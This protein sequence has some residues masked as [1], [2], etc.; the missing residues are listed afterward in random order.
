MKNRRRLTY[1]NPR[2]QA[3]R[4][5]AL[6][7]FASGLWLLAGCGGLTEAGLAERGPEGAGEHSDVAL[8]APGTSGLPII[9]G[10][11]AEASQI[12]GTVYLQVGSGNCTG[13]LIAPSVVVTA[14]HCVA[15]QPGTFIPANQILVAAGVLDVGYATND[16]VYAVAGVA[17]HPQFT[18]LQSGYTNDPTGLGNMY[19]LAV[20]VLARP[21]QT[22]SPVP[23]FP[24][25]SFDPQVPSGATV[26]ISGYGMTQ[27]NGY[28]SSGRLYLANTPYQRR[29]DTELLLGGTGVPDTCSGDSG[30]PT[31]AIVGGQP[32]LIGATSRGIAGTT[33]ECGAGGI[34]TFVPAFESWITEITG[35]AYT[36]GASPPGGGGSGPCQGECGLGQYTACTCAAND[37]CRWGNDGTCDSECADVV[38]QPFA[39]S[40][41]CAA[42]PPSDPCDGT[43]TSPA[44]NACTCGSGDP[45]GWRQDGV[46]DAACAQV[47][48]APFDDSVDCAEAPGDDAGPT[49]PTPTGPPAEGGT[50]P[51]GSDG[52]NG[53]TSPAPAPAQPGNATGSANHGSGEAGARQVAASGFT[54][55]C[56]SAGAGAA[57]WLAPW[58]ALAI[59]GGLCHRPRGRACRPT[60][61]AEG[62]RRQIA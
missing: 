2:M 21:V 51:D 3:I 37:P 58:A 43:C 16:Q 1:D 32:Y 7:A 28:G 59:L 17:A 15:P 19:D 41:D 56:A 62:T 20:L 11:P 18:Y 38:A 49:E 9:N 27:T 23:L 25:G 26:L 40:S 48:A 34:A 60:A 53:G 35:G 22:L 13:T 14:A 54:C 47:S 24:Y 44:Y 39:D 46:C 10:Q 61:P 36:P 12:F 50:G 31:Y 4:S 45:C 6:Y 5:P 33:V 57:R 29:S 8:W 42:P 52:G 55:A 30:G